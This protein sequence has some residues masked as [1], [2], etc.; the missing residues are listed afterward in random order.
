MQQD[1]KLKEKVER[2]QKEYEVYDYFSEFIPKSFDDKEWVRTM[3]CSS[4]VERVNY[5]AFLALSQH[6][7]DL[8]EMKHNRSLE[9][10][11][12]FF[13]EQ[14]R[15]YNAGG[16]GYSE[17]AYC[18]YLNSYQGRN[19]ASRKYR[20]IEESKNLAQQLT[21]G[22]SPRILFDCQF[23]PQMTQLIYGKVAK[24]AVHTYFKNLYLP[25]P[26][27]YAFINVNQTDRNTMD[28]F[29]YKVGHI[30]TARN[31]SIR[32][33]L[34]SNDPF[35]DPNE[36]DPL[37]YFRHASEFMDGP[38]IHKA[39]IIPFT[40]DVKQASFGAIKKGNYVGMTLPIRKYINWKSGPVF[41]P[42]VVQIKLLEE[43]R[44][45][46]GDWEHALSNLVPK[47]NLRTMEERK[48]VMGLRR[49]ELMKERHNEKYR[50]ANLITEA[51]GQYSE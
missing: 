49:F 43:V 20:S 36:T 10:T 25:S 27:P 9:H 32:P 6:R 42:W 29:L 7:K 3:E 15:I 12:T 50:I 33:E 2:I 5:W 13:K 41:L 37:F 40:F 17:D 44:R 46:G 39:Y 24:S 19:Y 4:V 1:P 26:F 23:L 18:L 34:Y 47:R 21:L 31:W 35:H 8:D 16:M 28:F 48:M 38:L 14:M 11:D 45:N 30:S 51:L 22:E